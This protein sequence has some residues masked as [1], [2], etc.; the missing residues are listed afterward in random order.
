MAKTRNVDVREI[1]PSY[2][3][4]FYS[5]NTGHQ[6]VHA[7]WPTHMTNPKT[8]PQEAA[9]MKFKLACW[10]MKALPPDIQ[11][12]FRETAKGTPFLPRDALLAAVYGKGPMI[13]F[14][15]GTKVP[16]MATKVNMSE[17]LD[18]IA[19]KPGTVL[20]RDTNL[21]KGLPVPDEAAFLRFDPVTKRPFWGDGGGGGGGDDIWWRTD[22]EMI[23]YDFDANSVGSRFISRYPATVGKV[24]FHAAYDPNETIRPWLLRLD[25][26]NQIVQV[27]RRLD[28]QTVP[29]SGMRRVMIDFEN[30]DVLSPNVPYVVGC[31]RPSKSATT[32]NPIS[33]ATAG[34]TRPGPVVDTIVRCVLAEVSPEVGMVMSPSFSG[35]FDMVCYMR[36]AG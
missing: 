4:R 17:V 33:T 23:A 13:E 1:G 8:A 25:S 20:Y 16:N 9:R 18:N 31:S 35:R 28:P 10:M 29:G 7:S 2:R 6:I 32:P 19:W 11:K 12:E 22:S 15:D 34:E 26:G 36:M 24:Y 21:W 30:Q 5:Y 14:P 27:V 3:G